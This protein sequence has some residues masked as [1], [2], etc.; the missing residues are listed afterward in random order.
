MVAALDDN[1]VTT[2]AVG[3]ALKNCKST[4]NAMAY[5]KIDVLESVNRPPP[6]RVRIVLLLAV[7]ISIRFLDLQ[8]LPRSLQPSPSDTH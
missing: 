8:F 2:P 6:I 1:P 5:P 7:G 3:L 4:P